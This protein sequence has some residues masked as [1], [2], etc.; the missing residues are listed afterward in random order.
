L[1]VTSENKVIHIHVYKERKT[2]VGY[3]KKE[4]GYIK[5]KRSGI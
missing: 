1:G 2:E 4:V 5:R 3:I